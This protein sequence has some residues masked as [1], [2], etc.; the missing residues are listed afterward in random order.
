[1]YSLLK[2]LK[3]CACLVF[4]AAFQIYCSS[5]LSIIVPTEKRDD[6]SSSPELGKDMW[7]LLTRVSIL[8]F[9]GDKRCYGSWKAPFMACVDKIPATSEYKMLK[10][11]KYLSGKVLQE[12]ENLGH[13]AEA[14]EAANS[15]LER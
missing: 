12:F 2:I 13:S 9:S 4:C 14:Y 10:F 1:M 6:E 8:L 5:T 7:K 15:T 3:Y 11:Q